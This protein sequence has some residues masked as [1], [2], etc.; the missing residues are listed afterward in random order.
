MGSVLTPPVQ[1]KINQLNS[2]TGILEI[3]LDRSWSPQS[4]VHIVRGT[5]VEVGR[6]GG[7]SA[8][9][10][11][12]TLWVSPPPQ[13]PMETSALELKLFLL[14]IWE[15]RLKAKNLAQIAQL[16]RSNAESQARSL[17]AQS[18]GSSLPL[19]SWINNTR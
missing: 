11:S 6:K 9:L 15:L 10:K 14:K 5:R 2:P 19:C 1:L 8:S 4:Q 17:K 12:C 13:S 3:L 16:V 7:K 18:L